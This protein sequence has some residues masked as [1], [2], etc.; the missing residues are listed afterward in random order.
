MKDTDFKLSSGDSVSLREFH[1]E[2]TAKDF[3]EGEPLMIRK[4]I[5]G[6]LPA[7]IIKTFGQTA[8]LLQT[9]L[10]GPLPTYTLFA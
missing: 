6:R 9:P 8:I 5:L 2:V 10:Q 3:L 4:M 1:M 7:E